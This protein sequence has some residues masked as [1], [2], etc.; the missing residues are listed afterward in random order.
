MVAILF[1]SSSADISESLPSERGDASMGL[2]RMRA[3]DF[4]LARPVDTKSR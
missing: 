4:L 3:K 1:N 2:L